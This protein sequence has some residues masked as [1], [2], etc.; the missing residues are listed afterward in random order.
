[1]GFSTLN[2]GISALRP[3]KRL[4]EKIVFS[5]LMMAWLRAT[6]PTSRS[7]FLL[8]ATTDGTRRSPSAEGMTMAHRPSSQLQLRFVVP[9]SIPIIF[10]MIA[11]ILRL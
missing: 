1:M 5:G 7:E 8:T 10:P 6:R 9:R 3:M 2:F 4:I 11:P